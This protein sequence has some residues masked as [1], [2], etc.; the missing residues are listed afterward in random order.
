MYDEQATTISHCTR[1]HHNNYTRTAK[2]GGMQV[3]C[4]CAP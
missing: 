4:K 3:Q 2:Q 1:T